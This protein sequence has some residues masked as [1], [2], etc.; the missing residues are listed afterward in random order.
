MFPALTAA[1][2]LVLVIALGASNAGTSSRL[3][4]LE[5]SV[6]NLTES[7]RSTQQ[8]SKAAANDVRLLKFA[9][10]SNSDKLSSVAEPLKELTILKSLSR[11]PS[12]LK[13]SLE[14]IINNGSVSGSCCP[15]DWDSFGQ[16]CYFFSKTLLSWEEARDWCEGHES[17][18]VILTN[19]KQWDFVVRL[20]AGA[21]Y[22][23]GLTDETG[24]WEWVNGTPYVMERRRWR[25]GQPD[26][27][28]GHGLGW[29]DEDCAHM[30]EDGRL[31]DLHCTTRL[32]FICQKHSQRA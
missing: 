4:V 26:S 10:G 23:V 22:W 14:R 32:R 3:W 31:N 16:S 13:C 15:L 6:L 19:D 27:W 24:K 11:T 7:Q 28:T 25:P 30:H 8:L 20:A 21:L 1:V 9:V 17:H 12:H 29:G 2:I 18:L 5:T